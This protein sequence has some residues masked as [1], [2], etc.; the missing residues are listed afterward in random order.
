MVMVMLMMRV[1]AKAM[2]SSMVMRMG[3]GGRWEAAACGHH[4]MAA[5][6]RGDKE[7]D[8]KTEKNANRAIETPQKHD[9]HP[10]CEVQDAPA[11]DRKLT[12]GGGN[13]R[14]G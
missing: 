9:N 3:M 14:A 8:G 12:R 11:D 13:K 2:A 6:E 1:M 5:G 10:A 4:S 7:N